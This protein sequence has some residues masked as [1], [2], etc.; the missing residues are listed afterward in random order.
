[1]IDL[2]GEDDR[3]FAEKTAHTGKISESCRYI[4]FGLV[5]LYYG[6]ATTEPTAAA[7][8]PAEHWS[9]F[10]IGLFGVLT[11]I[12]DYLHYLGAYFAV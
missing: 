11:L 8:P 6:L 12:F 2:K 1:M 3:L 9:V 10:W 7:S 4:G 5:A